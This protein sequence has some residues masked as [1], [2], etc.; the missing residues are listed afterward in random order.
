MDNARVEKSGGTLLVV[1][2][3]LHFRQTLEALLIGEG[4][5]VRCAAT[6]GMALRFAAE[7]PPELILLDIRLPDMDGFEVCRR[8]RGDSRT[9]R[10]PVIF[11]S[12]LDESADR[13]RGGAC[14]PDQRPQC[15][16]AWRI[17]F[18]AAHPHHLPG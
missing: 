2:D 4:Y 14:R 13:Y 12:G 6:G 3:D 8:L 9:G 1:D 17:Q 10:I 15:H 7:E 16:R 18:W 11:I 5:E